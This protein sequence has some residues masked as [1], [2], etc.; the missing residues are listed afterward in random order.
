M[1]VSDL[2]KIFAMIIISSAPFVFYHRYQT[3]RCTGENHT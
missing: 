2:V 1:L 3:G